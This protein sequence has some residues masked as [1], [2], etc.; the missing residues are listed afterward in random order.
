[1]ERPILRISPKKYAGETT[2]V[3]MRMAK[4]LLKDIDAVANVTG[5]TRN[6]IL[7]MSLEFALEHMEIVMREREEKNNGSDQV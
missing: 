4:D 5:R 3:S 2:I 7:T 6:E 1:M